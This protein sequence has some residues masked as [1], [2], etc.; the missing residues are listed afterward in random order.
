ML[1]GKAEEPN[2]L[3]Q[4]PQQF[5]KAGTQLWRHCNRVVHCAPYPLRG[6][7]SAKRALRVDVRE[8]LLEPLIAARDRIRG[9]V[10]HLWTCGANANATSLVWEPCVGMGRVQAGTSRGLR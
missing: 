10:A 8:D 5:P 4:V 9:A 1:R 3:F 6:R 7:E 2:L